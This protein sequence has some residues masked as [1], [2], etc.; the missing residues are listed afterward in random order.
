MTTPLQINFV[1]HFGT[2]LLWAVGLAF[3]GAL[4]G[5]LF[6]AAG[7]RLRWTHVRKDGPVWF[8]VLLGLMAVGLCTLI[9]TWTGF[10][11]GAVRAAAQAADEAG[12]PLL[13]SGIEAALQSA[14]LTNAPGV[15]VAQLRE[16]LAQFE[17][18][19]L[20]PLE[21]PQGG[22]LRRQIE[23]ARPKLIARL[24]ELLNQLAPGDR[25]SVDD[26]VT[27]TW[28]QIQAE[29]QLWVQR[30]TRVEMLEALGLIA[31]V[32]ALAM[33]CCWVIRKLLPE[34]EPAPPA[35]RR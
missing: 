27:K 3:L 5:G 24:R 11:I 17:Q 30:F 20:P 9:G 1:A 7:H 29:M 26:L 6:H 34:P 25:L 33:L 8:L 13:R 32:E 12:P 22:R 31:I 21:F 28:R 15:D 19:P 2:L 4:L 10:K 14:G 23:E 35:T 16:W 18:A